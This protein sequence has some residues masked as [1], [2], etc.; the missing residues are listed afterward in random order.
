[1]TARALFT[2]SRLLV[3]SFAATILVGALLLWLPFSRTESAAPISFVDA[4]FTSTS[5]VCVTGLAVRDTGKD[6]SAVGQAVILLLIQVGGLGILTFT[7][8]VIMASAGRLGYAGRMQVEESVGALPHLE[9]R[10]IL[11]QMIVFT[12][13]VELIGAVLLSARFSWDAPGLQAVWLGVFHSISAFCNAGFGLFSD[14]LEMYRRDIATNFIIMGLIVMGGLGFVVY[15]DVSHLLKNW[16]RRPRPRLSLHSKVVLYVTGI[17]IVTGTLLIFAME[18][19]NHVTMPGSIGD[20]L[21]ASLFLSVSSRTAGFNTIDMTAITNGTVLVLLILMAIGGSPGSTAGGIKTTTLAVLYALIQSRSTGRPHT[22]ILRR[23]LPDEVVSKAIASAAGFLICM[24]VAMLL[25]QV[26]EST[27]SSVSHPPAPRTAANYVQW[28]GRD[29]EDPR[30]VWVQ[31]PSPD[32]PNPDAGG[33]GM[34]A[35]QLFEVVSA[36]GTVGL[37]MGITGGLSPAGK[38]VITVCMFLGRLGPLL[39]ASSLL[40]RSSRV[41][42]THPTE[43]VI[44][45]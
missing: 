19:G 37:S 32:R 2:T 20:S 15:A 13:T 6:F 29:A 21:L 31:R 17:L 11:R 9:P 25:L 10:D 27:A 14:S 35:R 39:V 1:M 4:L 8:L 33:T 24:L 42:Y 12:L 43:A 18:T 23:S 22:E 41:T 3:V 34:F 38:L 16:N 7:N 44:V 40:A 26:T 45:G 30:P 36:L 28:Q 5:A